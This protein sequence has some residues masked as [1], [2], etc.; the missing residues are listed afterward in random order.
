MFFVFNNIKSQDVHFSQF[1]ENPMMLNPAHTGLYEGDFRA[2]LN[3][4]NQW[5]AISNVYQT[6]AVSADFILLKDFKS[7]K[8]TGVGI[9]AYQD[10]AGASKTKTARVDLNISQTIHISPYSDI[11]LGIGA[12][13]MDLSANYLGLKWGTQYSGIGY[14]GTLPTLESFTGYGKKIIDFSAGLLYRYFDDHK[15]PL[16]IGISAYH[17]TQPEIGII[18]ATDFLPMKWTFHASK[19]LNIPNSTYGVELLSYITSQRAARELNLGFLIRRNYGQVSRY[20]GY[21]SD[22]KFYMGGYYRI[23]DAVIVMAKL[24]LYKNYTMAISYDFNISKLK[25][26][27][28]L[29]GGPEVSFSYTGT[30]FNYKIRTPRFLMD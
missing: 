6:Y 22:T 21:Y 27:T 20:T 9:S 10:V 25:V 11:S 7:K 26:G 12:T 28:N 1:S 17:L 16:E 23:G 18:S 24:V 2:Y 8:I 4:K 19:E 5:A 3:Y 29:R 30:V 14:D 15:M 13:Y